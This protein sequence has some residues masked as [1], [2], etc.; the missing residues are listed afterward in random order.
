MHTDPNSVAAAA[1]RPEELPF[2]KVMIGLI[3]AEDSYGAWERKSDLDLL[4]EFVVSAQ[5]RQ[6]IPTVGEPDP[7][8]MHRVQQY[9]RAVG[10]RIEQRTGLMASP[11]I[12][13][14]RE[15]RLFITVGKLVALVKSLK[16]V[17]QFGFDSLA[18]LAVE[19][20]TAVDQALA[21]VEAFPDVARA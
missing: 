7:D 3:R 9:Y 17:H 11:T 2:V 1:T 16:D 20:E 19:G 12:D 18:A 14:R 5:E 6:A 4:D 10:L 21:A 15:N 8:L 13:L